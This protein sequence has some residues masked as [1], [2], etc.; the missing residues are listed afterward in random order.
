MTLEERRTTELCEQD[1]QKLM[2]LAPKSR[3]IAFES[4]RPQACVNAMHALPSADRV[5][6]LTNMTARQRA[7]CLTA[8]SEADRVDSLTNLP[9]KERKLALDAMPSEDRAQA[10]ASLLPTPTRSHTISTHTL[11][12]ALIYRLTRTHDS[13]IG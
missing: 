5:E 1:S 3:V 4:M 7:Q 11:I 12:R 8:M 2:G 13:P 9:D 10:V 6:T